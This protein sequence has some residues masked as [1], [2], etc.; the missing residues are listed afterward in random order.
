MELIINAIVILGACYMG[1]KF[2]KGEPVFDLG[3][4]KGVIRNE[5]QEAELEKKLQALQNKVR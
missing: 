5:A 3:K 4:F 2:G 1:Y